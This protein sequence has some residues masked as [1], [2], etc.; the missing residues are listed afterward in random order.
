MRARIH[1]HAVGE[2]RLLDGVTDHHVAGDLLARLVDA[3]HGERIQPELDV[4]GVHIC[5]LAPGANGAWMGWGG[6]VT[7]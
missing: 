7:G 1:S 4:P 2:D 3:D 5:L 6:A